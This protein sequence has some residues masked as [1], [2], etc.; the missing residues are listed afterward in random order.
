MLAVLALGL[1]LVTGMY[2]DLQRMR[3]AVRARDKKHSC[4]CDHCWRRP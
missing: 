1:V 4:D 2:L 3:R